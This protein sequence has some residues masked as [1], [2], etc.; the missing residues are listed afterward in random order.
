MTSEVLASAFYDGGKLVK[1]YSTLDLLKDF[2]AVPRSVSHY[3]FVGQ[4]STSFY[5]DKKAADVRSG[6]DALFRLP[7]V[8]GTTCVF[9]VADG[10]LVSQR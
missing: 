5:D 2:A 3:Q 8:D 1:S 7:L 4:G 10:R 6:Q 9:N